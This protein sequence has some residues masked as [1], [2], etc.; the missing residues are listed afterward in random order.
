MGPANTQTKDLNNLLHDPEDEASINILKNQ[1]CQYFEPAEVHHLFNENC[2]SLYSHNIRS[3]SGHFSDMKDVLCNILPATFSVIALQEIW[4]ISKLYDLT[5]YSQLI[6]KSRDM[7]TEPN[8]NC[9]GGVGFYVQNDLKFEILEEESVFISGV[10]ESLWIKV[11]TDKNNYKI[12]GNIY[13]PNSAPKANLNLA[14]AT[15]SSI[16]SK[17]KSNKNHSKCAIEIASDFNIDLLKFHEHV[18]TNEYLE[19]L[20]SFGL[21][22]TITK[23]TRI[24]PTSSTLIDH[25]FVS[26]KSKLHNSGIILTYLSDH[27]PVFYIDQST[28]AR[29]KPQPFKTQKVNN[30]TRKQL[31]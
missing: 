13:R 14:I 1:S 22:P 11:Q 4:S 5:G 25:I 21:L 2:F 31:P 23:P 6:Y 18:K 27:Y 3:L 12:I 19:T 10:Y 16:I 28:S 30:S 20:L 17:I 29:P 24:S 7:N 15:H 26:N 9:G 8:P